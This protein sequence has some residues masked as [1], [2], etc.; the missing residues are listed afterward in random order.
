M[1]SSTD[2]KAAARSA[3][4]RKRITAKGMTIAEFG[5]KAGFTRN[6]TYGVLK[7]RKLKPGEASRLDDLLGPE[8]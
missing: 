8:T 4:I 5:R 7:G 2:P 6:I 3:A 1:P